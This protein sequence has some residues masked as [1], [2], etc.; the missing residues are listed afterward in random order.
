MPIQKSWDSCVQKPKVRNCKRYKEAALI[1]VNKQLSSEFIDAI[2]RHVPLHVLYCNSF[3]YLR[4]RTLTA[5][6]FLPR[7]T[8]KFGTGSPTSARLFI[9]AR[10]NLPDEWKY[11]EQHRKDLLEAV[12]FIELIKRVEDCMCTTHLLLQLRLDIWDPSDDFSGHGIG[13]DEPNVE[14]VVRKQREFEPIYNRNIR[15]RTIYNRLREAIES[16]P[17]VI[18]YRIEVVIERKYHHYFQLGYGRR[19]AGEACSSSKTVRYMSS[20]RAPRYPFDPPYSWDTK[21]EWLSLYDPMHAKPDQHLCLCE[22]GLDEV[23]VPE[24]GHSGGGVD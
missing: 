5:G 12:E 10:F 22:S 14:E 3:Y 17:R 18:R 21:A 24:N 20:S 6:E 19:C 2:S 15:C 7:A 8:A 9:D 1:L 23:G 4:M 13:N 16:L 11:F